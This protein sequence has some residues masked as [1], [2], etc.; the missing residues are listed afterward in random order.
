M[1]V[2]QALVTVEGIRIGRSSLRESKPIP[3]VAEEVVTATLPHLPA[4]VAAMVRIQ[5]LTGMRPQEVCPLRPCEID[6]TGDVWLFRPSEHKTAHHGK[7]RVICIGPR[8]QAVLGGYLPDDPIVYCFTPAKTAAAILAQRS[9]NRKTPRYPSHMKHNEKRRKGKQYST[10]C[11]TVASYRQCIERGCLRAT[12]RGTA[13]AI[14]K[15]NQLRHSFATKARTVAGL[16]AAQA[17]LGHTKANTTEIYAE[18]TT[19]KAVELVRLMG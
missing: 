3:P 1:A 14:W 10:T 7:Q 6:R 2:Y 11:Y 15:P 9:A 8:A 17:A 13:I 5:Q 12:R 18:L 4:P 19:A 16:D